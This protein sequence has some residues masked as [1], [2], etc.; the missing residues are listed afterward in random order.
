MATDDKYRVLVAGKIHE[1]G[2]AVLRQRPDVAVTVVDAVET[3][4]YRPHLPWADAVL[5]RTQP[6][7]AAEIA[8][9]PRLRIVSRHGVGYDAVDV[10]ALNVR[11]IPLAIVGDVNS[12]AVAEHTM[13]LLLAAARRT[14]AHHLAATTGQWNERNRFDSTELDGKSLLILGFGRIGRRVAQLAGAFGMEVT[15]FDPF[16]TPETMAS[17]GVT[18]AADM[19]RA[20]AAAD[21]VSVHM[22]GGQGSLIGAAELAQMK[23]SAILVNA[24]R[25]GIVDELA[26]DAALRQRRLRAAALDVLLHE[27]PDPGHPLLANPHVTISPHNAGLTEECAMRMGVSAARNILDCFD[28]TLAPQLVVNAKAI[29]FA[30]PQPGAGSG[31]LPP[32]PGR[33]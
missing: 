31:S 21:Y 9:A 8:S 5:I 15:A 4:A 30:G 19:G 2:L 17:L 26:L 22:P 20:L 29:G 1:A 33:T 16:V 14:V 3:E 32:P 25:G 6:M 28:G 11:N 18:A 10:A 27:P 7:S 24:A 13:M 23:P 12:R